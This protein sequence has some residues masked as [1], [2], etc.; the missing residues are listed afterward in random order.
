MWLLTLLPTEFLE[1][2]VNTVLIIGIIATVLAFFV[3]NRLLIMFPPLASYYRVIQVVSLI[4]LC[5]GIYFKGGY[6]V[7]KMWRDRVAELEEKVKI[8]EEQASKKNVEIQEKVVERTKIVK[9]KGAEIVKYVDRWNTKEVIKEVEG[10]ERVRVEEVVKYIESCP[11]PKELIDLHN[12]AAK[13]NKGAAKK[14]ESK[15]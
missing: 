10:P 7:E 1:F 13:L 3:L 4:I 15:K 6:S 11:V 2:I 5:A 9:E 8:A 14:E 12:E